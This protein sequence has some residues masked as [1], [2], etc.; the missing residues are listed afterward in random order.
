MSELAIRHLAIDYTMRKTGRRLRAV[1]DVSFV[2]PSGAFVALIGPSGCGKSSILNAACGLLPPAAGEILVDGRPVQGTGQA[3]GMV[4]QSPALL[5]WRTVL[6]NVAYGLELR[7]LGRREAEARAAPFVDL[8]GLSG[9][10]HSYPGEL[11]GGMQQ[12]ANLARALAVRPAVLLLDEPLSA[13]D[14]LTREQ[15]QLE[16]Q[17]IWLE[18]AVTTLYVTHQIS[19]ALFLADQVLVLSGRPGRIREPLSV[20]QPRPRALSPRSDPATLALEER[21]RSLL[22]PE[23]TAPAGT[24]GAGATEPGRAGG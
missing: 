9:F 10:E 4:F 1:E 14:A 3:C 5:P 20:P 22:Q 23:A 24:A 2:V 19:E 17:R 15:M 16:L 13:L 21:I 18:T 7:G 11:S 12:R 6:R 8:V